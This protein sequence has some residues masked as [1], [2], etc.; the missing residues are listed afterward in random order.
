MAGRLYSRLKSPRYDA[1]GS[2]PADL[3]VVNARAFTS[4]EARPWAE[5]VAVRDGRIAYVGDDRG[6]ADFIGPATKVID[7]AGRVLTPGFVDNHCHVLWIGGMQVLSTYELFEAGSLEELGDLMRKQAAAFP[8]LPAVMGLGFR[9]EYIPGGRPDKALVDSI[10]PDRP[11]MIGAY[12]GQTICANTAAL[13]MLQERNPRAFLRLVPEVDERTGD[14]T[15]FLL[16]AHSFSI[17]DYFTI[18]ELGADAREAI[19][20]S[21]DKVIDEALSV[22]VTTMQDAQLYRPFVEMLLE[23]RRRGGLAKA[24]VRGTFF[25]GPHMLEDE[26]GLRDDLDWWI[27]T[28]REEADAHFILG[29]AVKLYIDGVTTSH[30]AFML[31]PYSDTGDDLGDAVWSEEGFRRVMEIVDAAG[32]QA[33]THCCGDAGLRRVVNGYVHAR[34]ANGERDSRH[35]IDHCE[36]PL[37]PEIER[38]ASAGIFAAM[39]PA[40]FYGD[41]TTEKLLGPERLQRYMPWRSLEASGVELSFGSD[42]CAGP[43]NPAYGLLIA[44]TRFNYKMRRDWNRREKVDLESGVRHWTIDSA[45]AL[46]MEDEVGSLEVGKLGDM[47]LFDTSPLKLDSIR[48]LLTH[49]LDVGKMDG[50]V[51]LTIVGGE[52]VYRKPGEA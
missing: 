48:F 14:Y 49:E 20:G 33:C 42:W 25:I 27:R 7:A 10:I 39:Q 51:N 26:Q 52:V 5:A 28:G 32:L 23:Y 50:F 44:A 46:R 47:V 29:D 12:S 17:L 24:R 13:Q 34:E 21:I 15:G 40:H 11:A 38:M 22:G 45:R 43:I 41:E 37:P 18:D 36:L 4:D 1:R 30:T 16:H 8:E 6:A 19:F 2:Q 3:A 35:R 9:Y 31:E